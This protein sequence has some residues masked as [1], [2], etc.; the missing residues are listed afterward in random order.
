MG[1]ADGNRVNIYLMHIARRQALLLIL[2]D[3]WHPLPQL[4][5]SFSGL[6]FPA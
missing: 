5:F 1:D 3:F 6:S 4:F 2:A